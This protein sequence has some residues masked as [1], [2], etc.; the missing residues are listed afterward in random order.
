MEMKTPAS[1]LDRFITKERV[2]GNN[3]IGDWVVLRVGLDVVV[4]DIEPRSSSPQPIT[5]LIKLSRLYY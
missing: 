1:H 2:P 4:L 3:W 5:T